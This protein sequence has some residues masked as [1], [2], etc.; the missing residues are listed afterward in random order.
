M[1]KLNYHIHVVSIFL[2]LCLL[3]AF[4]PAPSKAQ[5]TTGA[6]AKRVMFRDDDVRPWKMGALRAVNQVHI[7]E[8]VPVTLGVIPGLSFPS[9]NATDSD[10]YNLTFSQYI[11]SLASKT[12]FEIAQHGYNHSNN[13]GRYN[14]SLPSEFRGM[15]YDE[16]YMFIENGRSLMQNAFGAVPTTFIPPYYTGDENTLKALSALGYTVYSSDAGEFRL[17]NDE[18]TLK[19]LSAL[20]YTVYSSD[21]GEFRLQNDEKLTLEPMQLEL[22]F[23]G[24]GANS[25]YKSFINQTEALLNDPHITDIVVVYHYWTFAM[26][27]RNVDPA[28]VDALRAYIQYLK[29]KNVTFSTLSGTSLNLGPMSSLSNVTQPS[30]EPALLQL[31]GVQWIYA[32]LALAATGGVG[33]LVEC[34]NSKER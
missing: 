24:W 12:L 28:K 19:A 11:R 8:G 9:Q 15:S 2:V 33:I 25:T 10:L 30:V 29:T 3:L 13:S 31:T 27:G 23:D 16:Q 4:L 22:K 14:L 20:G 1:R 6:Q 17:Q 21:A 26:S 18:N 34:K 7:D 5:V 32:L